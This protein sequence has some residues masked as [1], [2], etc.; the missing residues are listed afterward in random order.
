[1]SAAS[2]RPA[3]EPTIGPDASRPLTRAVRGARVRSGLA[4]DGPVDRSGPPDIDVVVCTEALRPAE[5]E[6]TAPGSMA[7]WADGPEGRS[8]RLRYQA[9]GRWAEFVVAPRGNAIDVRHSDSAPPEQV[10]AILES[11]VLSVALAM[12]GRTCLHAAVVTVGERTAVIA[13]QSGAGKSTTAIALAGRG[14]RV[15]ADDVSALDRVEPAP[16]LLPGSRRAR[17]RPDAA[18]RLRP[19]LPAQRVWDHDLEDVPKESVR[20]GGD[21]LR[22]ARPDVLYLLEPHDGPV[23]IE[24]LRPV[25]A[26]PVLMGTRHMS[27]VLP[28]ATHRQDFAAVSALLG[29]VACRRLRRPRDLDGLEATILTLESD[30]LRDP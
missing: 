4:L 5:W 23:V 8:V 6:A 19:G 21:D 27:H 1:M 13:G 9:P 29:R 11:Q 24:E 28:P 30:V 14:H 3:D 15:I 20:L 22:G 10:A 18:R 26:L 7:W 25:D 12:G 2:G 16:F 17:L